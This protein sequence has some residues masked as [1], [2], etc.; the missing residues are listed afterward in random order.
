M[1]YMEFDHKDIIVLKK[2]EIRFLDPKEHM[3]IQQVYSNY[4]NDILEMKDL[5]EI[6]LD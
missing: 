5:I 3:V 6:Q 1:V 2:Q 4:P